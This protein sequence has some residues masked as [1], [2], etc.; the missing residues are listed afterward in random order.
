MKSVAVV[1]L[2]G[3]IA[4]P[5]GARA[6]DLQA[7]VDRAV[8]VPL[9]LAGAAA[10]VLG[11]TALK[12]PLSPDTCRWCEPSR[13]DT[14]LRD[15]LVWSRT[16]VAGD[17][18][19]AFAYLAAPTLALGGIALAAELDDRTGTWLDDAIIIGEATVLSATVNYVVK[20]AIGRERPF[21]HALADADKELTDHPQDNN[22][23][24]YSGHSAISMSL[25]VS[26]GT[27]AYQRGYA[28]APKILATGVGLSLVTGYLRIAADKHWTTDVVTGWIV[29]AALGY[30]IPVLHRKG[31]TEAIP[32]TNG[33]VVGVAVRW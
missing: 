4:A 28:A 5:L 16:D 1:A 14:S 24:F 12:G 26:A 33:K 27:V 29:G 25:A 32:T 8:H 19:D 20:A 6:E 3:S 30:W 11:E 2:V 23:S 13:L 18:S 21:V 31:S 10:Y 22:L 7:P 15:A 17:F 9:V